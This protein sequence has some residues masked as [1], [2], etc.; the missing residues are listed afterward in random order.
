VFTQRYFCL[1]VTLNQEVFMEKKLNR[2]AFLKTGLAATAG[3]G[4]VASGG[5]FS[6][7]LAWITDPV[8]NPMPT[9][10]LGRTGHEVS[11]FSLGGQATLEQPGREDD[12]VAII[13]RALDLGVNYID[14]ANQYGR[15]VSEQYIGAVLK[16]RRKEVFLATKSHDH[17]YDGTMRLV[18]QSLGRLQTDYIDLYQHHYVSTFDKLEQIR[19]KNGSRRAF[20]KLKDEG[21]IGHIGITSHSSRILTDAIEEYPYDCVL[22]TLNPA[23]SIMDDT[24][25]LDRFFRVATEKKIGIIAMKV[26]GG[27][28]LMSRGFTPRQLLSY[29]F[30]YPIST[31]IVG[32]SIIPHLEQN[33]EIARTFKQLTGE[34]MEAIRNLVLG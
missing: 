19:G 5:L 9:R 6:E 33:I 10:M 3:L 4:M 18:E 32:I 30:S 1:P 26:F 2:R 15:G 21:V 22:V 12:A 11:L 24:D 29:V 34:E 14:T 17:T 28:G 13:N 7:T 23:M 16:H 31:A 27:G 25:H 20:E 8:N